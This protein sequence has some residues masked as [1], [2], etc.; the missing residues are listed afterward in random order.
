MIWS[1]THR[2]SHSLTVESYEPSYGLITLAVKG[3]RFIFPAP[4]GNPGER[5]RVRA[6]RFLG[7][8]NGRERALRRLGAGLTDGD[9]VL[10]RLA[11]DLQDLP[12]NLFVR[13]G[14]LGLTAVADEFHAGGGP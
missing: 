11:P 13:D 12:A 4:P 2:R 9:D 5:R 3:G 6:A 8:P 7:A 1:R 10:T 14:I